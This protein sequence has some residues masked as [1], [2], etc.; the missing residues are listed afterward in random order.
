MVAQSIFIPSEFCS[1]HY[2]S[3]DDAVR[4]I[5][6]LGIGCTLAK[7]DVGSTFCIILVHPK[8]YHYFIRDEME[9]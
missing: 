2:T 1:I 4:I 7:I 3:V 9:G 8:E 6:M 5:K